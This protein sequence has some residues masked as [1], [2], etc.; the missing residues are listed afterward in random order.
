VE[1][2]V[3]L[4]GKTMITLS[5]VKSTQKRFLAG[6]SAEVKGYQLETCFGLSGCPNRLAF[7]DGLPERIKAQLQAADLLSFLKQTVQG[8]LKFHHEFR[9][10]LADCP[11]A[12]SQPQIKDIGILAACRPRV[13]EKACTGC[14]ACQ[15]ACRDQAIRVDPG[16]PRPEIDETRC[17]AC[18]Q[19]I[20][21]CPSGTL[22]RSIKG[23]RVQLGGKLGRHPRLG[24]ELPGIY[25]AGTVLA[26]LQDCLD[27]YKTESRNGR[28]LGELLTDERFEELAGRYPFKD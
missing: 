23:Y 10:A 1:E 4:A 15:T 27:L 6:M 20:A 5:E 26:I 3:R 2:E 18:G 24:R 9:I 13:T 7:D 17:V 12:C 21:V 25:P 14:E 16:I 11:N 22:G 8:D 19:C 28:R